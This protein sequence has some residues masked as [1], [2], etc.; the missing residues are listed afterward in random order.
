[1][2]PCMKIEIKTLESKNGNE[3]IFFFSPVCVFEALISY[4]N[5]GNERK[6]KQQIW[7]K[8]LRNER[9]WK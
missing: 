8:N 2:N 6:C 4:Y 9:K 5:N 3:I 1:M 7:K